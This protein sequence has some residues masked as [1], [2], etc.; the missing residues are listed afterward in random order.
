MS[1][2]VDAR[3]ALLM[4]LPPLMWAANAL[5][6]RLL[7]GLVP[8]L[9]MNFLR[10]VAAALI[11]LALGWR[12][13]RHPR[14]IGQRWAYLLPMGLLGVGAYNALQYQA[15]VTTTPINVTLIAS[16]SPVWILAVGALF[17]GERPTQ[18]A[19][20]GAALCMA[21]ALFVLVRGDVAQLAAIQLVPGDLY[22]LLATLAWAF[23]SWL[24]AK[25]PASTRWTHPWR[26]PEGPAPRPLTWSEFLLV[27]TLFGLLG[28]GA[29]AWV[30]LRSVTAPISWS[31]GVILALAFVAIGPSVVA[32]R[33]WALGVARGGPTL[34]TLFANLTPVFAAVMSAAVLGEMPQ[35][36]HLVAFALIASGII[37]T[38]WGRR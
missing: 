21:G 37:W 10:W 4:T 15:L 34:A 3:T 13:L 8:P 24:L 38:S 7:V 16:T 32:Y 28:A 17:Y 36:Y 33:C 2:A 25:P 9:T 1:H 18:H 12:V 30:E 23:Y 5:V 11:L 14:A 31:P 27:Q 20:V 19:L 35:W 6:G 29:A 22:I 26:L